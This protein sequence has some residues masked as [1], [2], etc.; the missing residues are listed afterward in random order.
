VRLRRIARRLMYQP[1]ESQ[2]IARSEPSYW[3]NYG[4]DDEAY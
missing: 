2:N 1:V 4:W 3:N